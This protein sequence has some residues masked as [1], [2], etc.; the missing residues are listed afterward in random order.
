M[1]LSRQVAKFLSNAG[2]YSTRSKKAFKNLVAR[3]K[4]LHEISTDLGKKLLTK[5]NFKK[6]LTKKNVMYGGGLS[7][8]GATAHYVTQYIRNNSGCF[9]YDSNG[10]RSCKVRSL[11]CCS[12]KN[13]P[14]AV[15]F[16]DDYPKLFLNDD[17]FLKTSP[18]DGNEKSENCCKYCD[19]IYHECD[20]GEKMECENPT[21][22]D[23]ISHLVGK[24]G[25]DI[26]DAALTVF[27]FL[28]GIGIFVLL[29]I[30]LFVALKIIF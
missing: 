23:A 7:A 13:T 18:C 29:V 8:V 15:Q 11:S 3:S 2:K 25:S 10:K 28:K 9:L 12:Q 20:K 14:E 26:F 19:C 5:K 30:F 21:V 4:P 27:P 1:G 6:L 22:N 16:C 17:N 24:V